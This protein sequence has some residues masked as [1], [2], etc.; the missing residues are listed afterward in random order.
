V[1]EI[2]KTLDDDAKTP[3]FI[4]TVH[5]RGFR[6]I[7]K[8]VRRREEESQKAKVGKQKSKREEFSSVPSSQF[9][10]PNKPSLIVLP[11]IN[12]SN[13]PEQEYFSD[14]I[15]EDITTDLSRIGSLFVISRNSAFTYKGKT[16]TAQD[17]SREMGVRYILEGS[18]RKAGGRIRIT[19]QLIDATTDHHLWSQRYDRP[20]QD[21][22]AL[23]DEVVQKIVTTLKLQLTLQEQGYIVHKHTDNL[24]AYD[25]YLRGLEAYNRH[26]KEA[27]TQARQ[28]LEQAITLDPQY[29]AAY[30][31]L[32]RTLTW[33]GMRPWGQYPQDLERALVLAQQAVALDDSL[34]GAH[35]ALAFACTYKKQYA[36]AITAAKRAIALAPNNAEGYAELAHTLLFVGQPEEVINLVEKAMRLNPRHPFHYLS[37]LGMAHLLTRRYE[38]ALAALQSAT[39]RIPNHPPAH[40][41]LLVTYSEI[42]R[43]LEARAELEE[44]RRI[45]PNVSLGFYR[46]VMVF[47]DPVSLERYLSALRKAGLK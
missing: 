15:T 4:E 5:R 35:E 30:A 14:G 6:F 7:G 41:H 29:A 20:L 39:L 18:V 44:I 16:A 1:R 34:P 33:E 31:Q 47:K 32:S 40:L 13:D 25:A 24:E 42:G 36:Q 9:A 27:L 8:V 19:A 2:R 45:N 17:V 38:E 46:R 12:M 26:T 10:L 28:L 37:F 11:F 22:F 3:Q 43:N 21:I 23:Q